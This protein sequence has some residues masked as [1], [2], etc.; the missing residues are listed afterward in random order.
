MFIEQPAIEDA[1]GRTLSY[2]RL[3]PLERLASTT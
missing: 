2:K 1:G 3:A